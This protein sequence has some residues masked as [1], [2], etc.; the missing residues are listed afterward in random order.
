MKGTKYRQDNQ[1]TFDFTDKDFW[2]TEKENKL[3]AISFAWPKNNKVLV[4]S[5][6]V[7]N[8]K[9]IR[10]LGQKGRVQWKQTSKLPYLLIPI[11]NLVI[12]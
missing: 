6:H 10:T 5:L 2:F 8:I 7:Q 12:L 4:A 9:S 1:V 11:R 3:Y